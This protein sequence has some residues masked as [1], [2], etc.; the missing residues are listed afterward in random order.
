MD[1]RRRR[2]YF[3]RYAEF[4]AKNP[5]WMNLAHEV[6]FTHQEAQEEWLQHTV[7]QA[8]KDAYQAGVDGRYPPG[9]KVPPAVFVPTPEDPEIVKVFKRVRHTAWSPLTGLPEPEEPEAETVVVTRSRRQP[10]PAPV[11]VTVVRRRR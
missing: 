10:E 7:A 6:L 1:P 11:A 4:S 8:L 5:E 3:Q 9:G 2:P